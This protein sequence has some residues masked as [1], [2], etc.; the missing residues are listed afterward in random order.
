MLRAE[1]EKLWNYLRTSKALAGFVLIGGT[2]LSLHIQHRLSEDLDFVFL[3]GGIGL[4]LPR[5]RL[6][7]LL[8][9]AATQG[10]EFVRN[11]NPIAEDEMQIAG[12]DLHDYQQDFLV[13]GVKVTF[14][15]PESDLARVI[16]P[17][18]GNT[19]RIATVDELFKTKALITAERSKTRDWFDLYTLLNHHGYS[20]FDYYKV[21]MEAGQ[22]LKAE[23]GMNRLCRGIPQSNDEGFEQLAAHAPT[24]LEIAAYFREQRDRYEIETAASSIG[25][26]EPAQ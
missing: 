3:D 1:T 18:T 26:E 4:R 19:V 7:A 14:F 23:N 10:F 21:F 15:V 25:G 12:M 20:I 8:I 6:N 5:T 22:P 2:A 11:D 16:A 9:D 24:I 17:N 13:N